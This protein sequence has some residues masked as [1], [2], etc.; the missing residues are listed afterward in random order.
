MG[1]T[2]IAE[3]T[4]SVDNHPGAATHARASVT[5]SRSP[6]AA[7]CLSILMSIQIRKNEQIESAEQK[8]GK[9]KQW[10][11]C[12]PRRWLSACHGGEVRQ[13]CQ[14]KHNRQPTVDLTD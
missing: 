7:E 12:N 4:R 9:R 10:R 14:G 13:H 6:S 2:Y 5:H 1:S 11:V 8:Q 3:G